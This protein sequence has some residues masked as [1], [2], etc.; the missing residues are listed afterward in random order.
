WRNNKWRIGW[1]KSF[2]HHIIKGNGILADKTFEIPPFNNL[3]LDEGLIANVRL[4][5]IASNSSKIQINCDSNITEH[6]KWSVN[7]NKLNLFTTERTR[8]ESDHDITITISSPTLNRV[9]IESIGN[10]KIPGKVETPYFQVEID[11]AGNFEA[12]SLFCTEFHGNVEGVGNL[13]V[14]GK[15]TKS[16]FELKGAGNINAFDFESDEIHAALEGIGKI[17][18]NPIN[19]INAKVE[20]IGKISYKNEPPVKNIRIEGLGSIGK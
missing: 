11:G 6:I 3:I 16:N 2:D 10:V 1:F 13:K 12:D 9:E 4:K 8:L 20:G 18:C 17:S 19:S 15:T 7:N 14:A 5:Q